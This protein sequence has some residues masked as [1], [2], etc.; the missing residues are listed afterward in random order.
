MNLGGCNKCPDPA[1][2]FNYPFS[3]QRCKRMACG[4]QA[5]LVGSREFPLRPNRVPG[6][7]LT[8]F[9]PLANRTL[10]PLVRRHPALC[11]F[12]LHSEVPLC[13]SCSTT[14]VAVLAGHTIPFCP[15]RWWLLVI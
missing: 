13:R 1:T 7:Q 8:R 12:F 3:L 11:A 6:T 5:H 2:A 14:K 9:D 10:N 15:G 4:H